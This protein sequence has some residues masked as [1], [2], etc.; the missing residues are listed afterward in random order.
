MTTTP[1]IEPV[2]D[3]RRE[4]LHQVGCFGHIYV[5]KHGPEPQGFVYTGHRHYQ[6][7]V[8]HLCPGGQVRVR[9]R[10]AEE[11]APFKSA[12]FIGPIN[13]EIAAG[14][15]HEITVLEPVPVEPGATL[16]CMFWNEPIHI[17]FADERREETDLRRVQLQA[18]AG[19]ILRAKSD[20]DWARLLQRLG[21]VLG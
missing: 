18:I 7:H 3:G 5:R 4:Y 2:Y 15:Y 19:Q 8:T 13:F 11:D 16:S 12:V 10:A 6:D 1:E 9:Y 20:A 21:P 17:P 14:V